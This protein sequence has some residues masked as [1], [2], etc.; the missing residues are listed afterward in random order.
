ML[1]SGCFTDTK[2]LLKISFLSP[3]S[4]RLSQEHGGKSKNP[5]QDQYD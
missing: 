2:A 5:D 1:F 3:S 4:L